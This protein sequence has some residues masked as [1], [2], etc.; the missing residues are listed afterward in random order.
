MEGSSHDP[1]KRLKVKS[2]SDKD[3]VNFIKGPGAAPIKVRC[4]EY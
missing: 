3:K 2:K 4:M 1:R